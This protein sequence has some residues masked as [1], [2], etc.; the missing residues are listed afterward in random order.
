MVADAVW[1]VLGLAGV[2]AFVF[3]GVDLWVCFFHCS[4]RC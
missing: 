2:F 3:F 4:I 1:Q